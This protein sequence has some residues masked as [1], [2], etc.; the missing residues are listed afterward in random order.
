MHRTQTHS[1]ATVDGPPA[2]GTGFDMRAI[3]RQ[4]GCTDG[5]GVFM[6]QGKTSSVGVATVWT[7]R[8]GVL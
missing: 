3:A 4:I 5:L 7:P 2:S 6:F 1:A 8:A